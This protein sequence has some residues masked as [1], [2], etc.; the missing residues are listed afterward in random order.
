MRTLF[1]CLFVCLFIIPLAENL[2]YRYSQKIVYMEVSLQNTLI[3]ILFEETLCEDETSCHTNHE[4]L[5]LLL[6]LMY[7][8][9]LKIVAK[10]KTEWLTFNSQK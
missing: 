3:N 8:F 7:L 1:V 5:L 9:L 4:L 2:K 6:F 10:G